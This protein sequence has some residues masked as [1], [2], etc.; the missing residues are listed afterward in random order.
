MS[1][2]LELIDLLR[3]RANVSYEDAKDALEKCNNDIVEA[4][5][6]LEK[7]K[8]TRNDHKAVNEA[9]FGETIKH[10]IKKGNETKFIIS[11]NEITVLNIPVNIAII[12]TVVFPPLAI[13]GLA[14]A[15]FTHH[16]IRFEKNSGESVDV[17]SAFDKMCTAITTTTTQAVESI[18]KTK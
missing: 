16:N 2:N 13:G 9:S 18:N 11:K 3:S 17:N 4:L 14:V 6:Y 10:L 5:V 1:I 15:I 12:S 8:K 7:Q